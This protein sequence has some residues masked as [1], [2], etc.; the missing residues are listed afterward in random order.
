[1]NKLLGLFDLIELS[2]NITD[3]T[4]QFLHQSN[5]GPIPCISKPDLSENP[6]DIKLHHKEG[7]ITRRNESQLMQYLVYPGMVQRKSQHG[8]AEYR[9]YACI[10]LIHVAFH[11]TLATHLLCISKHKLCVQVLQCYHNRHNKGAQYCTLE[12]IGK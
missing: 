9:S 11:P 7:K 8:N 3:N 5:R 10:L 4:V 1:M 6:I 12:S 2:I